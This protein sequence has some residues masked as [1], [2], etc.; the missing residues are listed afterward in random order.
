MTSLLSNL[1]WVAGP[2]ISRYNQHSNI[3]RRRDLAV[4]KNNL[5][6]Y[7]TIHKVSTPYAQVIHRRSAP[8]ALVLKFA[9]A[10]AGRRGRARQIAVDRP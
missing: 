3:A 6:L 7:R 9:P 5:F 10:H 2:V 8:R 4:K 1:A